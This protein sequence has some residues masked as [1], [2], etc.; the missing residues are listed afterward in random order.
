M[1]FVFTELNYLES[2]FRNNTVSTDIGVTLKDSTSFVI[3][4]KPTNGHGGSLIG[5][6][7]APNDQDDYR[8]FWYGSTIYYDYGGDGSSYGRRMY[9]SLSINKIYELEIGNYYIKYLNGNDVLRNKALTGVATS[10]KRTMSLFGKND[11][12]QLYGSSDKCIVNQQI[13]E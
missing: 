10:H 8:I 4:I 6:Y 9:K 7:K 11:Y 12:G 13:N 2:N 5:E 1:L 3:K